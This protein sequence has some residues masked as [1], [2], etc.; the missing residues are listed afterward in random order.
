MEE[1]VS[2][3]CKWF[4]NE[5]GYGFVI[6]DS[7]PDKEYFVHYSK[8]MMDNYKTLKPMQ[9]VKFVLRKIED[10]RVQAFDVTPC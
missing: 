5:R 9:R 4:S 10:G 8:I 3:V 2:G 6:P 1:L 7:E